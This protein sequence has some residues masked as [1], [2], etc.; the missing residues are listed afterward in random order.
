[1]LALAT[2][3]RRADESLLEELKELLNLRLVG[4]ARGYLLLLC[5]R[6]EG[7]GGLVLRVRTVDLQVG[8]FLP[9]HSGR[10]GHSGE[11]ARVVAGRPAS[12]RSGDRATCEARRGGT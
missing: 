2:R 10:A 4:C 12:W 9:A 11:H 3:L 7:K 1:M 8:I 5:G 6:V